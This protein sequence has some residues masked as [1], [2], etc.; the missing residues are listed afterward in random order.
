M[1]EIP[2]EQ[3]RKLMALYAQICQDAEGKMPNLQE[4]IRDVLAEDHIVF[5]TA[6]AHNTG[7]YGAHYLAVLSLLHEIVLMQNLEKA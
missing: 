4:I 6:V 5:R 1:Y 7:E 3:Q 2:P